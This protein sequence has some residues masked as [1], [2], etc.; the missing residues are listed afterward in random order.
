MKILVTGGAGFI[1]SNFLNFFV[2]KYPNYEIINFDK[3]TYAGNLKNT[4]EIENCKNYRFIKGDVCDLNFLVE[5]LRDCDAVIHFAAESHVDNSIG[6]SLIFTQSNILGT[7][8]LLEAARVSK[9][10][11]FLH[12]STDEV[13]GDILEGSFDESHKLSLTNPYSASKAAAEMM[14]NSYIKTYKLPILIYRANNNYGPLQY[15]EKI[16][17]KFATNILQGKKLPLHNPK[18]IRTY[19]HVLDSAKA[20]DII[21]HRGT[22]GEVYNV[23]TNDEL[24][25]IEV[26]QKILKYFGKDESWVESVKD[27]PFNDLRYSV[28]FSRIKKLGWRQEI[29]FETGLIETLKWYEENQD[30]WQENNN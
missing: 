28:D 8:A 3:L 9:I 1:G 13:Y 2:R 17:P 14:V 7:H 12:I 19:L 6:N 15:P 10:E 21:F 16:I 25:N 5:L 11:K 4:K 18:P 24:S 29:D 27:R 30:W 20:V 22:I 26:T 23:G